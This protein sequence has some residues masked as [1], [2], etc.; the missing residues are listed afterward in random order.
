M[1]YRRFFD[2][3]GTLWRV[4]EV[5]PQVDRRLAVRRVHVTKIYHP[6]RRVLPDRR[7][8]MRRS[9]LFFLPSE[10]SWLCFEADSRK[11]R[12][13]PIPDRWYLEDDTGLERL[14]ARAESP[15]GSERGAPARQG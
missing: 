4:W 9:R 11:L 5:I 10:S 1:S 2:S 13:T 12:L 6:D 14:C 15:A 7:L 8:D 3:A